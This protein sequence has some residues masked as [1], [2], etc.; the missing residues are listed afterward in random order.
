[1]TAPKDQKYTVQALERSSVCS[2]FLLRPVVLSLFLCLFLCAC[3]VEIYQGVTEPQANA[4][5]GVLLK[6]GIEAEKVSLGKKGFS[7]S[8]DEKRILQAFEVLRENNLPNQDFENLGQIFSGQ[9]MIASASEEQA[10]MSYALS[11]ELADTFSRI[12]GVLTSRVHV[13]LAKADPATGIKS[14]PS[15]AVFLRHTPESQA[16]NF[17]PNIRE[18]TAKSVPGLL[19][20][21]VFV[22]LVPVRDAVGVPMGEEN[23]MPPPMLLVAGFFLAL[24]LLGLVALG[25]YTVLRQRK[26]AKKVPEETEEI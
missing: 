4:M 3:K 17:V 18:V 25:V 10:R 11:Q 2:R 8:V 1:M 23:S 9:G 20:K 5:L 22:M 16:A 19:P 24:A 21:D 14:A 13:V 26:V 6:H 12:D 7:I 15:A